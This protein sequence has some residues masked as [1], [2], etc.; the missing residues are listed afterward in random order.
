MNNKDLSNRLTEILDKLDNGNKE[1]LI[2]KV[3]I[4]GGKRCKLVKQGNI[5]HRVELRGKR[6]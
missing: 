6:S 5:W 4:V 1:R 2:N 3:Y